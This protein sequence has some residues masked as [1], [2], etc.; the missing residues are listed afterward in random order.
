MRQS[1]SSDGP[2]TVFTAEGEIAEAKPFET[3]L[4]V[5]EGATHATILLEDLTGESSLSVQL[6]PLSAEAREELSK[7]RAVKLR[8]LRLAE[9]AESVTIKVATAARAYLRVTVAFFKREALALQKNFACKTCKQLCKLALS[10]MLASLGVPYLGAEATAELPGPAPL[11]SSPEAI[12]AHRALAAELGLTP[13]E[14]EAPVPLQIDPRVSVGQ[15]CQDIL[16]NPSQSPQ[17]IQDLFALI[18][19]KAI[20]AVRFGLGLVDGYIDATDRIYTAACEFMGM[21]KPKEVQP[22]SAA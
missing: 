16:T 14:L 19:P 10:A 11:D 6:G 7:L 8:F 18:H 2:V 9:N 12:A 21:C 17:W 22:T 15:A 4:T 5:P 13:E 3:E 20:A 1:V